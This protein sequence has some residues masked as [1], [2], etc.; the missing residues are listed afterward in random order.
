MPHLEDLTRVDSDLVVRSG[1]PLLKTS[2]L[3]PAEY[4]M[5][6]SLRAIL[7]PRFCGQMSLAPGTLKIAGIWLGETGER[8]SV[9]AKVGKQ[10]VGSIPIFDLPSGRVLSR[11]VDRLWKYACQFFAE[12]LR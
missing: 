6:I 1:N 11:I 4:E 10:V 3:A 12:R 2:Q 7:D 9:L 5:P 8:H